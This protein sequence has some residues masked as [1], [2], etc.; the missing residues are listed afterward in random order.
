MITT[1]NESEARSSAAANS[2]CDCRASSSVEAYPSL[3]A[4]RR[5]ARAWRV[6]VKRLTGIGKN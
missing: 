2:D 3:P 4:L 5:K 6:N 1:C